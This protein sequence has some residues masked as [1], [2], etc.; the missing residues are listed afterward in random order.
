MN[1]TMK[2][3]INASNIR[4]GGGAQ[5]ALSFINFLFRYNHHEFTIVVSSKISSQLK[6]EGKP[7]NVTFIEL[8]FGIK[9]WLKGKGKVLCE[10]EKTINPDVVFTVFGPSYWTPKAP[11]LMGFAMPWLINPESKAFKELSVKMWLK[12]NIQNRI[13]GF[14]NSKNAK[15][16]VVE[17]EDVKQRLKQYFKVPLENTWVVD[18][19]YNQHFNNVVVQPTK[20]SE[21]FE[22][23]TITA[24]YP[25]KNLKIIKKVIPILKSRGL[26][27]RFTLTIPSTDFENMFG[28]ENEYVR[29]LGPI[30]S[31]DCP[32]YY[33]QSDA[34]FLPTLL[35]CFTASY[36]EAMVM[37]RPILTSNLP[38]AK[39]ICKE[40]NALFFDPLNPE[41]IANQIE[42]LVNND[43]LYD[44][45][46][47]NGLK[48]VKEY[49][50][51]EQRAEAY[52]SILE[53]LGQKA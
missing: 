27:V 49:M 40:G 42:N 17:T 25:H 31:K 38:F 16:Y 53:K 4:F 7:K 33:N 15:Y 29:N 5:V 34:L 39:Q 8:D 24:N 23:I 46:V 32:K 20:Q 47:K 2:I 12:K 22:L 35:E 41:E 21:V 37:K 48:R 9:E 10:L 13:K 36:P 30:S 52:I 26:K 44:E 19:T 11:H 43:H 51:S 45:L 3:F 18:N 28:G 1:D 6:H 14:Y 50:T